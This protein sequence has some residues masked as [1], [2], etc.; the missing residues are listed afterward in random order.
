MAK[1]Q[2]MKAPN[3]LPDLKED[4]TYPVWCSYK[5]DGIRLAK[6]E[7]HGDLRTNSMKPL[8]NKA[9][10]EFFSS[11]LLKGFDSEGIVGS[12][13]DPL[14]F[15]NSSS[16][17]MSGG[18][19][20]K[21]HLYVF[22]NI[23]TP[24]IPYTE[25]YW[26][27]QNRFARLPEELK[28]RVHLVEQVLCE[29]AEEVKAFFEKA[30]GLGYEG[31]M[32]RNP[33]SLYKY[34]RA[35]TK[36]NMIFK[37]KPWKDAEAEILSCYELMHN[38]NEQEINELGLAKRASNQEN[39]VPADTLGGFEVRDLETGVE[40]KIGVM[41]GFTAEDRKKIWDNREQYPGK[42]VKYRFMNYG[43]VDKPRLP[44]VLGFRDQD[45]MTQE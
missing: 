19:D 45:D 3:Q 6:P 25:R 41:L 33:D 34:G 32:I 28:E 21:A 20:P 5:Y 9:T 10:Q 29:N 8:R 16:G 4:L 7:V 27:L 43:I 22:D 26:T 35:T 1:L 39:L 17:L 40:F 14:C 38:D 18:G 24:D 30:L 31:I 11:P 12:P 42:L 36:Q 13:V 2:P 15:S 23:D 37:M 44:K